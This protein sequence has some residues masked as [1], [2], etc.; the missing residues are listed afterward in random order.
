[1]RLFIVTKDYSH[2]NVLFNYFSL[3][4]LSI[5]CRIVKIAG[6]NIQQFY[7]IF[8]VEFF[9]FSFI[10]LIGEILLGYKQGKVG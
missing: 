3:C 5:G 9:M 7:L 6:A 1:M 10:N 8:L 4:T 2:I